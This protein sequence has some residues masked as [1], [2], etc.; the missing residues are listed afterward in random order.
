M[1]TLNT[2]LR[3]LSRLRP[4]IRF[5]PLWPGIGLFVAGRRPEE[6]QTTTA[7]EVEG[8]TEA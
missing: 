8:P 6:P 2:G 4:R 7:P 1:N 5:L 3:W